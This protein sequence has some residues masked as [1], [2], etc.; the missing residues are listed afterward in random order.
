[1]QLAHIVKPGRFDAEDYHQCPH[2]GTSNYLLEMTNI[3]Q[4]SEKKDAL[5]SECKSCSQTFEL[6]AVPDPQKATVYADCKC[7]CGRHFNFRLQRDVDAIQFTHG[8]GNHDEMPY[9]RCAYCKRMVF[10]FTPLTPYKYKFFILKRRMNWHYQH[11][12]NRLQRLLRTIGIPVPVKRSQAT[13]RNRNEEGA[14]AHG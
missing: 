11:W 3:R 2:C 14:T 8:G 6:N 1:M 5:V 10:L 12:K 4:H 7:R 13:S 9:I